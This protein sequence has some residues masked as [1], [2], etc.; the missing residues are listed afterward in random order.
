MYFYIYLC[1]LY[2]CKFSNSAFIEHQ[3]GEV[4]TSENK[5]YTL[6]R[7]KALMGYLYFAWQLMQVIIKKETFFLLKFQTQ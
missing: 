3:I 2:I 6:P 5:S 7:E 4:T 1:W